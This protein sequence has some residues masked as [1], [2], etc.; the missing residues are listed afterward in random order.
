MSAKIITLRL[1]EGTYDALCKL[2]EERQELPSE[3]AR[4]LIRNSL[5]S[6]QV[7]SETGGELSTESTKALKKL[8]AQLKGNSE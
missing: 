8:L 4:V 5:N 2:A 6:P 3:T 1:H 7:D